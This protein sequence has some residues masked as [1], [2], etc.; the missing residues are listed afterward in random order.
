MALSQQQQGNWHQQQSAISAGQQQLT[1]VHKERPQAFQGSGVHVQQLLMLQSTRVEFLKEGRMAPEAALSNVGLF[2]QP[3]VGNS[4][5]SDDSDG[6]SDSDG[7]CCLCCGCRFRCMRVLCAT[8]PG[9]V[10]CGRQP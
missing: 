6:A 9:L 10:L 3:R 8:A 7:L 1:A 2:K 4:S 5:S